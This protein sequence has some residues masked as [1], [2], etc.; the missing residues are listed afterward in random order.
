VAVS[1]RLIGGLGAVAVHAAVAVLAGCGAAEPVAAGP[2]DL[3]AAPGGSNAAAGTLERPLRTPQALADRLRP[4]QTGCLRRGT[5]RSSARTGYVVR[6]NEGGRRRARLTM[7]SRP[8]ERA[9]LAGVVFVPRGSDFVTVADLDVDDPTSFTRAGQLTV[10]V[11]AADT[12]LE[13]LDVTNRGRKTCVVLGSS[14]R[15]GTAVRTTLRDSVLHDCGSRANGMLDHAIYVSQAVSAR[16]LDN[17]IVRAAGYAVHLYPDAQRT[18]VAR[19]VMAGNGGGV[20]FAGEGGEASSGNVV[21]HNVI[22]GSL[23]DYNLAHYW[24]GRVGTG[25]AARENCLFSA[26]ERNVEPPVG[27]MAARNLVADPGFA[28]GAYEPAAGTPCASRLGP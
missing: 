13:G 5:Y 12:V 17:R 27:F 6:F 15:W 8:G 21:E 14:G 7:R 4:G 28:A 22:A 9:R 19:N 11:N 3:Y 10:Q 25:N 18:L 24:G 23:Q 1:L 2:C 16:I 20:I 26:G